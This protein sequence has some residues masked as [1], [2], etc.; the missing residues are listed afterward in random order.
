MIDGPAEYAGAAGR[1]DYPSAL[2][3]VLDDGARLMLR[4]KPRPPLLTVLLIVSIFGG[5]AAGLLMSGP[6]AGAA[7][8]VIG[9]P[10]AA[11]TGAGVL[12]IGWAIQRSA[13]RKGPILVIDRQ[14][15]TIALPWRNRTAPLADVIRFEINRRPFRY[16][17]GGREFRVRRLSVRLGTGEGEELVIVANPTIR[18]GLRAAAERIAEAADRPLDVMS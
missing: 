15:A 11:V 4:A 3:E 7:L 14:A 2:L 12:L 5:I 16:S 10:L 6:R 17:P 13:S 18:G 1:P 8:R 9:I